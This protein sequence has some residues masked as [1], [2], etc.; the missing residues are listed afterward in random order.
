MAAIEVLTPA[1]KERLKEVGSLEFRQLLKGLEKESPKDKAPAK[2]DK[3][4]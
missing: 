2:D 4:R 3:P 1:Q